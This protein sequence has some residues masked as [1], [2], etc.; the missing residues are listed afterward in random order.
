[1]V[2]T[3]GA[4]VWGAALFALLRS[5]RSLTRFIPGN[6]QILVLG[7]VLKPHGETDAFAVNVHLHD[8]YFYHVADL[9]NGSRVFHKRVRQG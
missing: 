4:R 1:M 3:S 7:F 9:H 2:T 5:R 8:F 6:I